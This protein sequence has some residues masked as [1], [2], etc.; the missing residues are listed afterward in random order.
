M[1]KKKVLITYATYGAG[2]KSVATYIYD[3]F[4]KHSNF[5]IKIIDLLDY[6]NIIGKVSKKAFENNF[7]SNNGHIFFTAFY[8]LFNHKATTFPYKLY[9][10]AILKNK[11]LKDEIVSFNPD[12][13]ISSH[14]FGH[15]IASIYNKAGLINTKIISIITDYASHEMW[16]KEKDS[17]DAIIVSNDIVA[18]ELI[19]K[20]IDKN[21]IYPYGIPILENFN[22]DIDINEVKKK[23]K[24]NNNK[25]TFLFFAGGS[26]G[27]SFTYNYLKELLARKYDINIIFV[28]GKN[29]EVKERAEG[30][31]KAEQYKN[32]TILGFSNEVN[33]LLKISDVVISKPGGLCL[34]ECLEIKKPILVIPGSGGQEIDNAKFI[35]KNGYGINCNKSKKLSDVVGRLIKRPSILNNL[36]KNLSKYENNKSVEKIYDLSIKLLNEK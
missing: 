30:L 21:K 33:K 20:K 24:V 22:Q 16:L 4:T 9:A 19:K 27:A 10:Q 13:V 31:V 26:I 15:I 14:F 36:N 11:K 32:I 35:Y 6:E 3:Y 8:K 1:E 5:E 17:L 29:E 2:H 7:K 28:C 23:Y 25:L 12:L 18:N 34:T